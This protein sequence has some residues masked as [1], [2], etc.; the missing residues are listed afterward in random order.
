MLRIQFKHRFHGR[1]EASEMFSKRLLHQ[2]LRQFPVH[3]YH[4]KLI[5]IL[6]RGLIILVLTLD[7]YKYM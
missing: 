3:R 7:Y 5:Y 4:Y 1:K 2:S 6:E